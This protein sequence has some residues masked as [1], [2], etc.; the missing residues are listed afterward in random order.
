MP[1]P[2]NKF[3]K[4]VLIAGGIFLGVLVLLM[5]GVAIYIHVNY[6]PEK[7]KAIAIE[8]LSETLKR[9][10]TVGDVQFNV[11]SGFN[12]ANLK[13][14]NRPGWSEGSF[15]T[16]KDISISYKLFPLLWGQIALGEVRLNQP[17]ILVE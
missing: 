16:A 12:I 4:F 1:K 6:P 10:V 5:G 11:F 7:L 14:S 2:M 13:I 17:E 8:K 3:F 9:K 15:V